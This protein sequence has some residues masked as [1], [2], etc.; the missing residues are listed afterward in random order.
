VSRRANVIA[1]VAM[2]CSLIAVITAAII[3]T[4]K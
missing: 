4:Y 3:A 1:I 2:V